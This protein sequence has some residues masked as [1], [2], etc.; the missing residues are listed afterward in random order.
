MLTSLN[1]LM[2][3]VSVS[4]S[5][6]FIYRTSFLIRISIL[7]I[8]LAAQFFFW[9]AAFASGGEIVNYTFSGFFSYLMVANLVYEWLQPNNVM[10]SNQIR[11][12]SLNHFLLL[13][14]R[15]MDFIFWKLV[16]DR[17]AFLMVTSIPIFGSLFFFH[18]I[19]KIDLPLSLSG[20][21]LLMFYIAGGLFLHFLIDFGIGLLS[22][23]FE[24]S[25]F[26]FIVKELLLRILAGLWFPLH[27]L[28]LPVQKAFSWLPFQFLGYVPSQAFLNPASIHW[29]NACL[30]VGWILLLWIL[31]FFIWKVG[32][33]K[34]EAFGA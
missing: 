13:P 7:T 9:Q 6:S 14:Y 26:L 17:L 12:G 20:A 8:S 3:I 5:N 31:N 27:I 24:R 22:F 33:K 29:S 18:L 30:L 10:V 25:E 15:F 16:G 21:G 32:I 2:T 11:E 34:Y 1:K 19:G 4:A 28:P 23:W